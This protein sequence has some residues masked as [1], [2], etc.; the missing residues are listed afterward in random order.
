MYICNRINKYNILIMWRLIVLLTVFLTLVYY[1][2][3]V[4]HLIGVIRIGVK[5][6][7]K[8][9]YLIPFWLWIE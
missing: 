3:L 8:A 9:R 6:G 2:S 7:F 5:M 1:L 4:L